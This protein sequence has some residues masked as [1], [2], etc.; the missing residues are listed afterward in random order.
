MGHLSQMMMQMARTPQKDVESVPGICF[1]QRGVFQGPIILRL[2][3]SGARDHGGRLV[4][5]LHHLILRRPGRLSKLP[6]T[7]S[8]IASSGDLGADVVIQISSQ[9]KHEMSKTVSERKRLLPE[10]LITER[11]CQFMNPRRQQ[12]IVSRKPR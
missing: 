4:E 2:H 7:I 9:M 5:A 12:L 11:L 3:A 10:L 1:P 6:V 8:H